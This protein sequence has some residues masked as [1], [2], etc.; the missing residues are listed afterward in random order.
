MTQ[1]GTFQ[2][3]F[4]VSWEEK[5]M[6]KEPGSRISTSLDNWAI[7]QVLSREGEQLAR[8]GGNKLVTSCLQPSLG[9][10]GLGHSRCKRHSD[11]ARPLVIF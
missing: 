1:P 9:Q 8:K 3:S 6:E 7:G 2:P 11:R 4:K 10:G 5:F